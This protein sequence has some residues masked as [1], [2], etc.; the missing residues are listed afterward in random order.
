[1]IVVNFQMVLIS[2]WYVLI[3]LGS[4]PI[5]AVSSLRACPYCSLLQKDM[6]MFM[7]G[8]FL[9]FLKQVTKFGLGGNGVDD[10]PECDALVTIVEKVLKQLNSALNP[11]KAIEGKEKKL[12]KLLKL[13]NLLQKMTRMPVVKKPAKIMRAI[14]TTPVDSVV[15]SLTKANQKCASL[16][17]R[18]RTYASNIID[19][20]FEMRE[21]LNPGIEEL[22]KYI[23]V[24]CWL[25]N[26]NAR[27]PSSSR[28]R[29]RRTRHLLEKYLTDQTGVNHHGRRLGFN[30]SQINT[31]FLDASTPA[32]QSLNTLICDF[33][34]TASTIGE[35][36]ADSFAPITNF[37]DLFNPLED[38][39][40]GFLGDLIDIFS[41][42]VD[43]LSFL[44]C[45]RESLGIFGFLCD[46]DAIVATLIE[47]ILKLFG[48]D[49]Q[50]L[51][52]DLFEPIFEQ[53]GLPSPEVLDTLFPSLPSLDLNLDN[54]LLVPLQESIKE[55]VE[56]LAF[57]PI[58]NAFE[59][60][61]VA[62][63]EI[64]GVGGLEY[65]YATGTLESVEVSCNDQANAF[66]L[67]LIAL[68]AQYGCTVDFTGKVEFPCGVG[69][70]SSC[71]IG[72]DLIDAGICG[73]TPEESLE[74]GFSASS[75]E[76]T[77]VLYTCVTQE[78]FSNIKLLPRVVFERDDDI[79][80]CSAGSVVAPVRLVGEN[81]YYC[82]SVR[83][84]PGC[85][86][87]NGPY[88]I[89]QLYSVCNSSVCGVQHACEKIISSTGSGETCIRQL[90][91]IDYLCLIP[92]RD[93]AIS[94]Q[95][96]RVGLYVARPEIAE[97]DDYND[98]NYANSYSLEC[99]FPQYMN[100]IEVLS[101]PGGLETTDVTEDF[102]SKCDGER[103]CRGT[104]PIEGNP[105]FV[106]F[107]PDDYLIY[108]YVYE[109]FCSEGYH[110][111]PVGA[112]EICQA[113]GAGRFR[114]SQ[115][116][117]VSCQDCPRGSFAGLVLYPQPPPCTGM[118]DCDDFGLDDIS[119]DCCDNS[120]KMWSSLERVAASKC[121]PCP[122]GTY[123][124]I[125]GA[126]QCTECLP[127]T[128]SAAEGAVSSATCTPCPDDFYSG[129][130]AS[131]C[132]P[133]GAGN[134]S[135]ATDR[136]ECAPVRKGYFNAGEAVQPCEA[137]HYANTTGSI[138]CKPCPLGRYARGTGSE[139][140]VAC[141]L[142]TYGNSTALSVC[143]MCPAGLTTSK[144]GA[145]SA[146]ECFSL[147]T[148]IQ[149]SSDK[150][151]DYTCSELF[152]IDLLLTVPNVTERSLI[153]QRRLNQVGNGVCNN[154]PWNT[155]Q[156]SRT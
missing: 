79:V 54:I 113:C 144:L 40:E 75:F 28:S 21:Y 135:A 31:A 119:R 139:R 6:V 49:I 30:A 123:S 17:S 66:P 39:L 82:S 52:A 18:V 97:P 150:Y 63:F 83:P 112:R 93:T 20:F 96:E 122:N 95:R 115:N 110:P 152:E 114:P 109:C 59:R 128:F 4:E 23:D 53:L 146:E 125:E 38:V 155:A 104:I 77:L 145:V 151:K 3:V 50:Q 90:L 71:T 1:M 80:E 141:P 16:D 67:S 12:N 47:E 33:R 148:A 98:W 143:T 36:L 85:T 149:Y 136:S 73:A 120:I 22:A 72:S 65:R 74:F 126:I 15:R 46:L 10:A 56:A 129:S 8:E 60:N 69:G 88:N 89:L 117:S 62:D 11:C 48:L 121:A 81:I 94:G 87:F 154:Q 127:G 130:G 45:P 64:E 70:N 156:V 86:F 14:I 92:E 105:D 132:I 57:D 118:P 51:V 153:L 124:S 24:V 29:S 78:Q 107:E 55:L 133:C 32:L 111:M 27:S 13:D 35:T 76:K 131:E 19:A 58:A 138:E 5:M 44:Q 91:S 7:Q 106:K 101:G 42:I 41:E 134:E 43:A 140:C 103:Y 147:P 137:G 26:N 84:D 68:V 9:P 25:E 99:R 142:G 34:A 102:K 37:L 108:R 61:G 100:V 116:V 2:Q